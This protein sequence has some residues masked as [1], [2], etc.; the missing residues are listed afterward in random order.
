MPDGLTAAEKQRWAKVA[1]AKDP[2][3]DITKQMIADDEL[4][5]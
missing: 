5:S 1:R 4:L 3:E 2:L